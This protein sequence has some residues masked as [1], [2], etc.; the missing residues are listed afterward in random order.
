MQVTDIGNR[1]VDHFAVGLDYEAQHAVRTGVLRPDA[2][3]HVFRV[4]TLALTGSLVHIF[5]SSGVV[6]LPVPRALM[7][8]YSSPRHSPYAADTRSNLRAA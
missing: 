1:L 2:D 6:F 4:K 5:F 3:S 7:P 8:S